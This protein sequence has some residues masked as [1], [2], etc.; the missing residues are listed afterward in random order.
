M[1]KSAL[2]FDQQ[3]HPLCNNFTRKKNIYEF[4]TV[5]RGGGGSPKNLFWEIP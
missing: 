2:Q 4:Y 1:L 3:K 5:L